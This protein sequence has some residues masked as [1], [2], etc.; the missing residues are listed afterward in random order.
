MNLRTKTVSA[1]TGAPEVTGIAW[2]AAGTSGR[3]GARSLGATLAAKLR[4]LIDRYVAAEHTCLPP[5]NRLSWSA[6]ASW[7]PPSPRQHVYACIECGQ[8]W[9]TGG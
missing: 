2:P 5:Q 1:E 6:V 9:M 8:H 3:A 7:Q 4:A